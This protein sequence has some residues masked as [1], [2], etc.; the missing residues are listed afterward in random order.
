MNKKQVR[1]SLILVPLMG[2]LVALAGGQHSQLY[3]GW[4]VLG[5]CV[6]FAFVFNWLVFIP[7][8]IKQTEKFFDLTGSIT[9]ISVTILAL[10]LVD[11]VDIRSLLLGWLVCIWA[12]RLGSFLYNRISKAGKDDRFDTIKPNFERFLNV[13]TI[14][15]LWVTFTAA[16]A[17]IAITSTKRVEIGAF[18]IIGLVIWALGFA[19][20][21]IA[22]HQKTQF[23]NDPNNKEKF[24]QSG[25]W[26]ISRHPNYLGEI[27][28]WVGITII[29]IPTLQGWQWIAVISP[30]FV[31][32][33]LTKV[34]GVP[35]LEAKAEQKWGGQEDYEK[36]KSNTP[37]LLPRFV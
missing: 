34:S 5:I 29:A 35:M 18:A 10:L 28:L 3:Q 11:K 22:D 6:L 33:L 23:R 8:F 32:L 26:S 2:F 21:V 24:I 13:W 14:Q 15:G 27:L 30:I 20:E 4:S 31:T 36:Y 9:Y 1:I 12:V 7:A 17:L 37:V 25:L 16:P 19:I